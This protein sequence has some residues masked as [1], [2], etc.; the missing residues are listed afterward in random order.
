MVNKVQLIGHVGG[1]VKIH[2]FDSGS[3]V[4][5]FTLATS[6]TFKNKDGEK[7]TTTEWHNIKVFGKLA[8][9]AQKWVK[10]GQMLFVEG[11]IKYR[12]YEKDGKKQYFTEIN[13]FSFKMLGKSEKKENQNN[14][15]EKN[16]NSDL[17][18]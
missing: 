6:E 15:S 18:F 3:K 5:S 2:T 10:K 11:S 7:Q 1:D 8:D 12:E 4:A 14:E 17:P 16:D 13:C 9:V